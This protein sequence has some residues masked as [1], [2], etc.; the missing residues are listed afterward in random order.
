MSKIKD[1]LVKTLRELAD[2]LDAG[3][4]EIDDEQAIQIMKLVAHKPLSKE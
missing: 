2:N 1:Y 4:S 3:N